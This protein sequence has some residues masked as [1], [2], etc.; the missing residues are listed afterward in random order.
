MLLPKFP[1]RDHGV[2]VIAAFLV[3]SFTLSSPVLALR[4]EQK[5]NQS[6]LEEIRLALKGGPDQLL[7]LASTA[8]GL[9]SSSVAPTTAPPVAISPRSA[10]G[11]EEVSTEEAAQV[12]WILDAHFKKEGSFRPDNSKVQ[13]MPYGLSNRVYRIERDDGQ[14]F[15]GFKM[16]P[17]LRFSALDRNHFRFEQKQDAALAAGVLPNNWKR[18]SFL[19]RREVKSKFFRDEKGDYWRFMPYVEERVIQTTDEIPEDRRLA[20]MKRFGKLLV[21]FRQMTEMEVGG[22][23]EDTLPNHQNV[24]YHLDFYDRVLA[25]E[26][27]EPPMSEPGVLPLV[28]IQKDRL[29][30]SDEHGDFAVRNRAFQEKVA[31]YRTILGSAMGQLRRVVVHGDPR[32]SNIFWEINQA[33]EW[34]PA[35]LGDLDYLQS[36]HELLD[37]SDAVRSLAFMG[38]ERAELENLV[39]FRDVVEALIKGWLEGIEAAYGRDERKRLESFVYLSVPAIHFTLAIRF[40]NSFL[41]GDSHFERLTRYDKKVSDPGRFLRFAEVQ[42]AQVEAFMR[43]FSDKPEMAELPEAG[44]TDDLGHL[45]FRLRSQNPP[46]GPTAAGMEEIQSVFNRLLEKDSVMR[47]VLQDKD[48]ISLQPGQAGVFGYQTIGGFIVADSAKITDADHTVIADED[49]GNEL[50]EKALAWIRVGKVAPEVVKNARL[51]NARRGDLLVLEE[52]PGLTAV[53]VEQLLAENGIEGASAVRAV[54]GDRL[55]VKALPLFAFQLFASEDGLPPVIVLS[56]AVQLQDK[57]GNAYTLILMA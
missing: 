9:T 12:L 41:T 38:A 55:Q 36:G 37:L 20:A 16:Q 32:M 25:G 50:A 2:R 6:G 15:V 44:R 57:A 31:Q 19:D 52:E 7:E 45:E 56:V 54:M 27:V 24:T 49:L 26:N 8:F 17:I 13:L 40:Y 5:E 46:D 10:A 48:W 53:Q 39:I 33:G 11:A 51:M 14:V 29:E 30:G 35:A 28:S 3:L 21:Q 47:Q 43:E 18:L 34:I 42:M 1:D 23:F 4:T 22:T